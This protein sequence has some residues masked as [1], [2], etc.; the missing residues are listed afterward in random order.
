MH[1]F[2][3]H[4][5]VMWMNLQLVSAPTQKNGTKVSSMHIDACGFSLFHN[6]KGFNLS[7][8]ML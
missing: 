1:P 6:C 3:V 8:L 7:L 4:V 5:M 2:A